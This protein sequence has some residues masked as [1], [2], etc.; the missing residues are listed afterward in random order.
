MISR[1]RR[2]T[3]PSA[4]ESQNPRKPCA[5]RPQSRFDRLRRPICDRPAA[6]WAAAPSAAASRSSSG[7]RESAA[8]GRLA[9]QLPR[10]GPAC[11]RLD[12]G[13]DGH[14]LVQCRGASPP[15]TRRRTA[16]GRRPAG[17]EELRPG[18]DLLGQ[19]QHLQ[20]QRIGV[21]ARPPRP[22]RTA[23]PRRCRSSP[24][25]D[26]V[27]RPARRRSG[28]TGSSRCRRRSWRRGRGRAS[29]GVPLVHSRLRMPRAWAP[30]ALGD[31]GDAVAVAGD[32]VQDRLDA[33]RR[34]PARRRPGPTSTP[35]RGCR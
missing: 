9:G 30:R 19:P 15:S 22:G 10:P 14:L 16:P 34:P 24:T 4:A 12:A 28:A 32:H 31:Q 21:R 11:Q 7:L 18:R 8:S 1:T 33:L 29:G 3:S 17:D 27:G 23:R 13:H 5:T 20:F 6:R 2:R 35:D 25:S 26:A